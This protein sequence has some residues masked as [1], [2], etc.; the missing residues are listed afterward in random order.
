M[1][2]LTSMDLSQADGKEFYSFVELQFP[3]EPGVK[4]G[5]TITFFLDVHVNLLLYSIYCFF[6]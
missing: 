3:A 4:L 1:H 5:C 2:L 6:H